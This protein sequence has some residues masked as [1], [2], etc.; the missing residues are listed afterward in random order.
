MKFSLLFTFFV[1]AVTGFGA[2]LSQFLPDQ[3]AGS[4][5]WTTNSLGEEKGEAGKS[6]ATTGSGAKTSGWVLSNAAFE[7]SYR[8]EAVVQL[9]PRMVD[10]TARWSEMRLAWGVQGEGDNV[11]IGRE[12]G[13]TGSGVNTKGYSLHV[14]VPEQGRKPKDPVLDGLT[15]VRTA[16]EISIKDV[17][18]T[19]RPQFLSRFSMVVEPAYLPKDIFPVWEEQYRLAAEWEY[20]RV[21][22]TGSVWAKL[23]V[24][25]TP[26][27]AR[28]YRDGFFFMEFPAPP[29]TSGRILAVI[30]PGV[31]LASLTVEKTPPGVAGFY[32]IPL[33]EI[34]NAKGEMK[35]DSLPVPGQEKTFGG[36]PFVFPPRGEAGDHVDIGK[37]LF[38]FRNTVG[39]YDDF[40]SARTLWRAAT[41]LDSRRLMLRIPNRPYQRLW[42]AAGAGE[43]PET[44][45][46]LTARFF[47]PK[48]GYAVDATTE[49]PRLKALS[50][51]SGAKRI[52]VKTAK[53]ENASLWIVPLNLDTGKIL[54][55]FRE[56]PF[57]NIELTK[58]VQDY[59]TSPD[60][61]AYGSFQGGLA[62]SVQ[63]YAAT[64]EIAPFT[65]LADGTSAGKTYTSPEKPVWVVDV[66]N[67]SGAAGTFQV[68]LNVGGSGGHAQK[69]EKSVK[70]AAG[71]NGK[72][73][74]HLQPEKFG[75]HTVTTTVTGGDVSQTQAGAFLFLPPDERKATA[76]TTRW[77]LWYWDM[78]EVNMNHEANMKVLHAIGART[79]ITAPYEVR[80]KFGIGPASEKLDRARLPWAMETPDDPKAI[81]A[82]REA[83]AKKTQEFLKEVPD[84]EYMLPYAEQIISLRIS[85]GVPPWALGEEPFKFSPEE[86]AK[87][88]AYTVQAVTSREGV[89]EVSK[90]VQTMLGSCAAVFTIPLLE[91]GVP[92]DGF[93]GIGLDLPQFE[94]MPE[95]QPRATEPSLLYFAKEARDRLGYADKPFLHF[96]SYF[97]SSHP[98]ATGE[99]GQADSLVR[100]AVLSMALGSERFIE[101]WCFQ[102]P[103]DHWG[104]SHYSGGGLYSREPGFNPKPAAA[105]YATMTQMLD[106]AKYDGYLPTGSWS[107]YCVR[108][109]DP[110]KFTYA[111]WTYS[112]TRP[113][114]V[115][116]SEGTKLLRVDE[117]G[118]QTPVPVTEGQATLELSATPF[119]LVATGGAIEGV[120][121]GEPT[122]AAPPEVPTV[123]L[124]D[125]KNADW[126]YSSAPNPGYAENHWD[127][128]RLPGEYDFSIADSTERKGKVLKASLTKAGEGPVVRW[129]AT[130]SPP[131]PIAIPGKAR[132][133]GIWAKGNSGWGRVIYE[134][135]D[136]QGQILRNIGNKDQFNC[137]DIHSW[138][139]LN[140]D[141]WKFMEFP[142]PGNLPGDDYR[143][144]DSVWWGHS[145]GKPV[146]L[147]LRLNRI[148]VEMSTHIVYVNDLL[149]VKNQGVELSD[150]VALYDNE[151]MKSDAPVK[152]QAAAAGQV[153]IAKPDSSI[154]PN[155]IKD[156]EEH[157]VGAPIAIEDVVAPASNNDGTRAIVKVK[158]APT[159]KA[160]KIWLS[161]YPDGTGAKEARAIPEASAPTDLLVRGLVPTMP[162][163][164]F[165]TY[166]DE[167]KKES[168]PSPVRKVILKDEFP[169]K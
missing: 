108:F 72:V 148:I 39:S 79:G 138:S 144:K 11:T 128:R 124:E 159:A 69:L 14:V 156:L 48:A 136:A 100:T 132:S 105:A 91:A 109:K 119:W 66:K 113:A 122:H 153:E 167:E 78:H 57:F 87:I 130:F 33:D 135:E 28:V 106:T 127:V 8:I 158:P 85:H 20:E 121:L 84:L 90:E 49:V 47:K 64:L 1:G 24:V 56:E 25:V 89:R 27:Y 163:Y 22:L 61:A 161:A 67:L 9:V 137:D 16:P 168:K 44:I 35:A 99:R 10:G 52:E 164:F 102:D 103:S 110:G 19:D 143:E 82:H 126:T 53:G 96:E 26:D 160:Y 165:A 30:P 125:F 142:L 149:E 88:K 13:Y 140:F 59:R 104:A 147:P 68:A 6:W 112:G 38:P 117:G 5:G 60:P 98:L 154:L 40:V 2:P 77:G 41:T 83:A 46:V 152:L 74:F 54:S 31:R 34:V 157:G 21:P 141:G 63:V 50:D 75:H 86:S 155:P 114:T 150:L 32:P 17:P 95:R 151:T 166:V 29:P 139:S 101:S 115:K 3:V 93:D 129:Y 76:K 81:A 51:P 131:K 169:F 73:E 97:P 145:E 55:A 70:V 118:N 23:V 42:V 116:V 45:P 62:S 7:G 18:Y 4:P 15:V 94:R 111:M 92:K 36:V 58:A 133:L 107:S 134:L 146:K 65:F 43:K 80:K 37:S 71:G 123:L 12:I 162:L 120:Q